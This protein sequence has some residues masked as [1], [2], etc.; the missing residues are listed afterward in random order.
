MVNIQKIENIEIVTFS[1]TKINA[2]ITEEIREQIVKL[3][4]NPHSKVIID[5]KGVIY[6]DSSGFGCLLSILKAARNNYGSMKITN[7]EAS[8][9]SL[10]ETLHLHTIFEIFDNTEEC[11][12]SFR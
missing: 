7:P 10:L 11:M 4:E 3:F 5:L 6:I 8:V 12:R 1:V 9:K 2:L